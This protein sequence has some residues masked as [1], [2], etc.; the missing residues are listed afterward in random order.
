[1][2][3][4]LMKTNIMIQNFQ[5]QK[6]KRE[7]VLVKCN[8]VVKHSMDVDGKVHMKKFQN[9]AGVLDEDRNITT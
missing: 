1:M 7:V 8:V 9:Y 3:I 5:D 6:N 2:L 4:G